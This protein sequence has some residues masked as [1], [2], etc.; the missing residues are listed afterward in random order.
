MTEMAE[1]EVMEL[2]MVEL[3]DEDDGAGG[4]GDGAGYSGVG[5]S[6]IVIFIRRI[7]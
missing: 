3:Y 4:V 7:V 5:S 2:V 1:L 6:V